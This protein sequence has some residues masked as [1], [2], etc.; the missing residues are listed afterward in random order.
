[1]NGPDLLLDTNV[2]I[3]FLEG[4]ERLAP[5]A[6][7]TFAISTITEIEL[8]GWVGIS[9]PETDKIK[10]FIASCKLVELNWE[11]K[12]LSIGLKQK[13]KI[14]IPDAIIAA[15]A[16]H[17][18]IPLITADKEFRKIEGIDLFLLE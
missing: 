11:V 9:A 18:N 4:D 8:L 6:S 3:Y 13:T 2:V 10:G 17:L 15:S 1:V 16:L 14:K 12:Q 7:Y 5:F